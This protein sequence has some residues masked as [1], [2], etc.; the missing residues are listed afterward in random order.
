MAI[1]RLPFGHMEWPVDPEPDC[2]HQRWLSEL[3][4][5]ARLNRRRRSLLRRKR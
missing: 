5:T 2:A 1:Y 4:V 3:E